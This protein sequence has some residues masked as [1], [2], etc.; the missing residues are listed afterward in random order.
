[1]F[2]KIGLEWPCFARYLWC[3]WILLYVQVFLWGGKMVRIVV[4]K[5]I[6]HVILACESE[7]VLN[8]QM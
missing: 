1:M 3:P 7:I 5:V 6:I 4:F 8:G 2:W